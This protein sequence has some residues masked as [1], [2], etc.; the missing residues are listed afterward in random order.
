MWAKPL[1]LT[2]DWETFSS[3]N[4][5]DPENVGQATGL[6]SFLELDPPRHDELRS[7]VAKAFTPRSVKALQST[8]LDRVELLINTFI[9]QGRADLA[10]QL[11][12]PLP[13]GVVSHLLGFAA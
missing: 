13:F 10:R 11:A 9:D 6:N 7:I 12:W 8:A 1:D 5:V 2:R 3:A 4:G